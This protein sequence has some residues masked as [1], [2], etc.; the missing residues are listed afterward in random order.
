MHWNLKFYLPPVT[1][2]YFELL[3]AEFILEMYKYS[4]EHRPHSAAV[5][6]AAAAAAVAAAA[7][8]TEA[9]TVL[10]SATGGLGLTAD[11][12]PSGNAATEF[13][14]SL[15]GHTVAQKMFQI[16]PDIRR[17]LGGDSVPESDRASIEFPQLAGS[18]L[19]LT[20]PALEF[21]K[22]IVHILQ[23]DPRVAKEANVLR[24][25]VL[26]LIGVREFAP[27]A[28]FR[29]PCISFKLADVV[30]DYCNYCHDLDLGRDLNLMQADG[31]WACPIC[32]HEYNKAAIEET[33]IGMLQ[34]R[35]TTYQLQDLQCP[36]C[37]S[38]KA[39][40]MGEYCRC[41][42]RYANTE[43]PKQ[44]ADRCERGKQARKTSTEN[45]HGKQDKGRGRKNSRGDGDWGW[46]QGGWVGARGATRALARSPLTPHPSHIP[47]HPSPITPRPSPFADYAPPFAD[48][49]APVLPSNVLTGRV[50]LYG[51]NGQF[52]RV[53]QHCAIL[54]IRS[55]AGAVVVDAHARVMR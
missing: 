33:L 55:A 48:Y 2:R 37:H 38:V 23:L 11:D 54:Q 31:T 3:V 8:E 24:K 27:D 41:S 52:A 25:N 22:Y 30:C 51:V 49:A 14:R 20:N 26:A 28:I 12:D 6:S 45:K 40:N 50:V 15:V 46:K 13:A 34:R 19:A 10:H 21:V 35:S 39:G 36:K 53:P 4:L 1:R 17:M 42:G 43:S 7:A 18:H 44:M 47:R 29:D 5:A 16:L 32:D 9:A